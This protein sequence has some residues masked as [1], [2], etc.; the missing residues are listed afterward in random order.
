MQCEL[1]LRGVQAGRG[2]GERHG[3]AAHILKPHNMSMREQ[4]IIGDALFSEEQ[5]G[6]HELLSFLKSKEGQA[7]WAGENERN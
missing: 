5:L 2:L 3:D 6:R 4:E 1:E 7:N